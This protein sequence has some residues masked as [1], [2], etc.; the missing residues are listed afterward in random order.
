MG[1]EGGVW[2][3]RGL[4]PDDPCRIRTWRDLVGFV[5]EAGF[6]PLFANGIPGFSVEEHVAPQD[7]WTGDPKQD[8]WEWR[9]VIAQSGEVAYGKFFGGKSGFVSR[10]WFPAFANYRRDGYDFDARWEDGLANIRHKK[11]MDCYPQEADEGIPPAQHMGPELKR[12]AGFGK[13]GYKNFSGIMTEL[14]MQTYLVIC[15]FERRKDKKGHGYGM[16]ASIYARPE[17]LW[18]YAYIADAYAE[19]PKE[20]GKR[21]YEQV[22]RAFPNGDEREVRKLLR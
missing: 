5:D 9:E 15:G 4:A 21:I 13:G 2:V 19:D 7:W 20:S 16:P 22:S 8:P 12:L 18:G 11:V 1:N 14:Q 3:M 10:E 6:L 17:D